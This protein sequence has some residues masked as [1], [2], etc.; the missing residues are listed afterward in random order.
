MQQKNIIIFILILFLASSIWLFSVADK[1]TNPDYQKNWWAV[2]FSD[3]KG[4]SLDF[5][6]ENHSDK[7]DFHYVISS[8]N[9]KI[10]EAD[11]KIE[12]GS[13]AKLSP[14]QADSKKI[15]IQVSAREEK[16]EIYKNFDK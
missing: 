2:Y 9:Q 10:Q 4:E 12:K 11:V 1:Y 15:T 13:Q 8:D 16:K 14:A 6:I 5:V 3:P 7:T